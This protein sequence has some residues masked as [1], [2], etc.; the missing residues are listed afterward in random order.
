[1]FRR[2]TK[3]VVEGIRPPGT[4][5]YQK[6]CSVQH[7]EILAGSGAGLI[8]VNS[9]VISNMSSSHQGSEI[10]HAPKI[11]IRT[12]HTPD[13]SFPPQ[14]SIAVLERGAESAPSAPVSD[15]KG[16]LIFYM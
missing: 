1:M 12:C 8:G 14:K 4:M 2:R 16:R 5:S 11:T 13:C 9:G 7:D 15:H 3:D 10:K 6:S